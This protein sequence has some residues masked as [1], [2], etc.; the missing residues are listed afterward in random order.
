M[1]KL[2]ALVACIAFTSFGVSSAFAAD[3]K[4]PEKAEK[5]ASRLPIRGKI[6]EVDKT[7]KTV[8]IGEHS[9]QITSET[10]IE[11]IGNPPA[12]ATLDD[13]KVGDMAQGSYEK[14][15]GDKLVMIRLRVGAKP[16]AQ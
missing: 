4:A 8:K 2:L 11:K 7:A 10:K 6:V 14:A 3:E 16:P 15:D 5:K 1:K 13:V 9:Y 12:P